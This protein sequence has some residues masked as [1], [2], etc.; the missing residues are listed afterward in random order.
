MSIDVVEYQIQTDY[1]GYP[2]W[3]APRRIFV[4]FD[5]VTQTLSVQIRTGS[6]T[7]IESP[8]AGPGL[9]SGVNGHSTVIT[10]SPYYQFCDGTTLKKIALINTF[11]YATL[12]EFP[13]HNLCQ[14]VPVCDLEFDSLSQITPATDPDTADG[15]VT[16]SATS[17]NGEIRYSM[18]PNFDYDTAS[19]TTGMFAGLLPSKYTIYAKDEVGC[20]ASI[21]INI[22]VTV[23]YGVKY[24][25]EYDD[26]R[27]FKTKIDILS[28]G[29]VGALTEV[30]FSGRPLSIS[31]KPRTKYASFVPSYC[32]VEL[33]E[34]TEDQFQEIFTQDER[35]YRV[36]HYKDFGAGWVLIWTGYLVPQVYRQSIVR[37]NKNYVLIKASDQLA[38]LEK[39]K[40]LDESGNIYKGELSQLSI[41]CEIL[42]KTGLTI[43]LRSADDIFDIGMDEGEDPLSQ[44]FVDTRIFYSI[45]ADTPGLK[46]DDMC[47]AV[48]Q[49]VIGCKSGLV[50]FQAYGIW[51]ITRTENAVGDFDWREFDLSGNEVDTGTYSPLKQRIANEVDT[52]MRWA[53]A[54]Q[55]R[56]FDPNYGTYLLIHTLGLDDNF[57]D[58]GRFEIDDIIDL[59]NG[60]KAFK[61]WNTNLIQAG[62]K[63]GLEYVD[64][65]ASRGAFFAD[66]RNVFDNQ[67]ENSHYC[68]E[69]PIE[70]NT[71][72]NANLI[73]VKFQYAA[74]PE[75][76]GIPW[77]RL[78]WQ[79]RITDGFG[80]HLYLQPNGG[81][82]DTY[83]K[84]DLYI[85]DYGK[86]QSYE[87]TAAMPNQADLQ[88]T[89]R[90]AFFFHN[91]IGRDF[92]SIAHLKTLLVGPDEFT[93]QPGQR[94][95]VWDAASGFTYFY[96]LQYS[97]DAESLPD[98]V[99]PADWDAFTN[100]LLWRLVGKVHVG[101]FAGLVKKFLIDN[102]QVSYVPFD[103]ITS[104]NFDPPEEAKYE[105]EINKFNKLP[106]EEK[107]FLGD[108]PELENAKNLYRGYLRL[109]DGTPTTLW[110][111]LGIDEE[112]RLLS[113]ALTDRIAQTSLPVKRIEAT[114]LMQGTYYSYL[115]TLEYEDERFING[116]YSIEDKE[117]KV[118][119][120]LLKM[121]VGEDGEPPVVV[122]EFSDAFSDDFNNG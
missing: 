15:A 92:A 89:V 19:N 116:E 45:D 5:T 84:N 41:I 68:I 7:L 20:Y 122:G 87:I 57:I 23:N 14:I 82:H 16:V 69:I 99:H 85:N 22:P 60:D 111:R 62:I 27:G 77:I 31:Y 86:F 17:S 114:M 95:L 49:K 102:V 110:H 6:G 65:G 93:V 38:N 46:E 106:F 72:S 120:A 3:V 10:P 109:A 66:F 30:C 119:V 40:F 18:T 43:N 51:W 32:E 73:K 2:N 112:K 91:H 96:E 8:V 108:L 59:G 105:E 9:Y 63:H 35:K 36:D 115:D 107:F 33:L 83:D 24:S 12:A 61:N 13:N 64:N 117:G 67:G 78:A 58:E 29:Y 103:P 79:V 121:E 4:V 97:N 48:L 98:I 113:I 94:Y 26:Q 118:T 11:P 54:T 50:L 37:R 71:Y 47:D 1:V 34:E 76:N 75:F 55:Q 56:T 74:F 104:L 100:P 88:G 70:S 21:S 52:G 101:V 44:G 81:W 90:I 53:E 39:E 42:K 28:R 80:D 25:G